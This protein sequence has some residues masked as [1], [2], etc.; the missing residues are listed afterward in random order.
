MIRTSEEV[1]LSQEGADGIKGAAPLLL[2]ILKQIVM[3]H[4]LESFKR[5]VVGYARLIFI[6]ASLLAAGMVSYLINLILCF[7]AVTMLLLPGFI[8]KNSK[9]DLPMAQ[10][11]LIPKLRPAEI[12]YLWCLKH[13]KPHDCHETLKA[14]LSRLVEENIISI[15]KDFFS[16]ADNYCYHNYLFLQFQKECRWYE[17]VALDAVVNKSREGLLSICQSRLVRRELILMEFLEIRKR[18]VLWVIPAG[19][20][21]QLTKNAEQAL[22]R[23]PESIKDTSELLRLLHTTSRATDISVIVKNLLYGNAWNE[24]STMASGYK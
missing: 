5:M 9:K 2:T 23:I 8:F 20:E 6:P 22:E 10:E 12:L 4:N 3:R 16:L 13:R 17:H 14:V 21:D 1:R 7:A 11:K 18:K 19:T 15:D 24:Q